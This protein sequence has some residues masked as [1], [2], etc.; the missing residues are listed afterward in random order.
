M[1]QRILIFWAA[2]FPLLT[3]FF[4]FLLLADVVFLVW[5]ERRRASRGLP[6]EV[7]ERIDAELENLTAEIRKTHDEARLQLT[8]IETLKVTAHDET[9]RLQ[10]QVASSRVEVERLLGEVRSLSRNVTKLA[11]AQ[12]DA[13]WVSP[14]ALIHLARHADDWPRTASYLARI[15]ME[16]ATSKNL[17]S[18]AGICRDQGFFAKA[19]ELYREAVAKDPENATARIELLA[20]SAQ[21]SPVERVDSLN[22]LQD[23][24]TKSLARPSIATDAEDAHAQ[25][26]F[27]ETLIELG[28][29]REMEEYCDAQLRQPL[30][31]DAQGVLHRNLAILYQTMGRNDDALTHCEAALR[32]A[33]DDADLLSLYGRLLFSE[34]RYDEAYRVTLRSLQRSPTSARNYMVLAEIQEKRLGRSAS[35]DLLKK[36]A[37]WAGPGDMGAIEDRLRRLSALDELSEV[38]PSTQPQIIQAS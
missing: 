27:F 30:P 36:A 28:R 33:G 26:R 32:I 6:P 19:V 17:E 10:N 23:L 14:H 21:T 9:A 8:A 37:Q 2:N 18:A 34:E 31:A 1:L 3:L 38:I 15:D 11:P 24:V 12:D 29:Y 35:R 25:E 13:Q 5:Q 4:L 7:N 16:N 22:T 20:L